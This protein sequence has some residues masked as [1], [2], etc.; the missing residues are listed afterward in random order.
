MDLESLQQAVQHTSLAALGLSFL[1]G[2]LFSF[3]PVALASIP[4]SLAYVTKARAGRE[5]A[6]FGGMFIAGLVLTHL[7]LGAAAGL[8]GQS[9]ASLFG[10]YW[11]LVLG[12]WLILMGLLWPGWIRLPF[13]VPSYRVQRATGAWGAFALGA[14]FAVAVCPVC[15]PTL[16]VLLG[17]VAGIGS[18]VWGG[19][20]LLSF[21]LGRAVPIAVGAGAIGWLEGL[22]ALTRY[23]RAFDIVGGIVLVLAGLYLL[24]AYFFVV[25]AL[26]GPFR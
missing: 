21:G 7:L 8:A 18:P 12:P 6:L 19:L 2:L 14:P 13:K 10:R 17:V 15:T 20:L 4:V 25:P 5:A 1:A 3:N 11:G 9:V 23:Q 24:N 16:I 22:R 26:A